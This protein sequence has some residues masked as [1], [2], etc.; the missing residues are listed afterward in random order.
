M[1]ILKKIVLF[2]FLCLP[3]HHAAANLFPLNVSG[4]KLAALVPAC[5]TVYYIAAWHEAYVMGRYL[6]YLK[7]KVPQAFSQIPYAEKKRQM[8]PFIGL[9]SALYATGCAAATG[10][11]YYIGSARQ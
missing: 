3:A 2:V 7:V 11:L 1:D 5:A 10:L 9:L 6:N 8:S 4:C